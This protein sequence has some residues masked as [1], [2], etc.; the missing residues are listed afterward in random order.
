LIF[1]RPKLFGRFEFQDYLWYDLFNAHLQQ[2]MF[3][4]V[5]SAQHVRGMFV[6]MD[7]LSKQAAQTLYRIAQEREESARLARHQVNLDTLR[8]GAAQVNVQTNVPIPA[9]APANS[10]FMPPVP[11][12]S[13]DEIAKKLE[14]LKSLLDK[15]LITK[16]DFDQRKRE[17][18]AQI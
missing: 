1:F 6:S 4:S 16:E 13:H 11:T 12:S 5:F 3:G 10:P 17:L 8:A 9:A 7:Y 14:S 2:N 15:G 18:L